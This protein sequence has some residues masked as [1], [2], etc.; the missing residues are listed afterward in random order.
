[1]ATSYVLM[2]CDMGSERNTISSLNTINGV[3]ESHGTLGL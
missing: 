1:M 2:N 3:T